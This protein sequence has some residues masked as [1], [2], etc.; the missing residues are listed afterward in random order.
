MTEIVS[1]GGRV[2]EILQVEDNFADVVLMRE[3]CS[4]ATL[5]INV[6]VAGD[7]EEALRMLRREGRHAEQ[8]RPDLILLDLNLPGM[9]GREVLKN[10][11][12]DPAL[13]TIPVIIMTSSAAEADM[14]DSR[15]F[16]ANI[17]IVKPSDFNH[18]REI[19]ASIESFWV[20]LVAK[21]QSSEVE[22]PV[23]D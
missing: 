23:G 7:G 2:L 8:P 21:Q 19:V 10:I 14:R 12:D 18:L 17:Y 5:P 15:K 9:D 13:H 4:C 22:Q 6:A 20:T 16:D 11:K 1:S 3:A